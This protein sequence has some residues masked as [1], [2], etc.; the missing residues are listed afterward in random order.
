MNNV[1]LKTE[2]K[3][4]TIHKFSY[5]LCLFSYFFSR[6]VWIGESE[7]TKANKKDKSRADTW[8]VLNKN[9]LWVLFFK[10]VL[11]VLGVFLYFVIIERN[12]KNCVPARNFILFFLLLWFSFCFFILF[13]VFLH[14]HSIP[15]EF[16]KF[17]LLSLQMKIINKQKNLFKSFYINTSLNICS[18]EDVAVWLD[19][20]DEPLRYG[21][22]YQTWSS[23]NVKLSRKK[24]FFFQVIF[25]LQLNSD[26]KLKKKLLQKAGFSKWRMFW[27]F[28]RILT[29]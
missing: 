17:F 24:N 1:L 8:A 2:N 25:F 23:F 22:V 29:Q 14:V 19:W 7:Y 15:D 3:K 10:V 13:L 18:L 5:F 28:D 11:L 12:I 26:Q 6:F 20:L 16:F 21:L 9:F 4:D 27:S